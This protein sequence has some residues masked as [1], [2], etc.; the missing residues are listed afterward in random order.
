MDS[1]YKDE[2]RRASEFGRRRSG[3]LVIYSEA[4]EDKGQQS[5]SK[6]AL[7]RRPRRESLISL[8]LSHGALLNAGGMR[9]SDYLQ[10]RSRNEEETTEIIVGFPVDYRNRPSLYRLGCTSL[11]K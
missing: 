9:T 1:R 3:R 5:T 4:F 11:N 10:S 6:N 8:G 2:T 7:Q